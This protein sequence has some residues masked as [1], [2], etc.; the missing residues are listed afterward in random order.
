MGAQRV[1]VVG[2]G[3]AG[4]ATCWSLAREH[5]VEAV[6][7][8]RERQP[9]AHSTARNAAILRTAIRDPLLHALARESARFYREPPP[10]F[11]A[12]RLLRPCGVY[13]GAPE[14]AAAELAAWAG[15]PACAG[16]AREVPAARLREAWPLL[17]PGIA[18]CWLSQEDGVI[19]THALL[20]GFLRQAREAGAELRTGVGAVDLLRDRDGAVRGV[21]AIGPA[22]PVPE[23]IEADA[24]VL[25]GGGWAAEPAAAA[26]LTL[27]LQPR[28]R[29]LLVTAPLAEVKPEAPVA[30]FFGEELYFRPESGGLLISVCDEQEVEPPAGERADA[31][32]L[33]VFAHK[34]RRWLPGCVDAPVTQLLAG[35]RTFAADRRFVLGPD[36]RA[37][38]LHWAAALGGHGIS[39]AYAA[40]RIAAASAA[41]APPPSVHAE[42][43]SPARLL[44]GAAA[45]TERAD[46]S[47]P[48]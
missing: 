18:R 15:D 19:D 5:G 1:V 7:I 26:G 45:R 41:G 12:H 16:D 36:P 44:S 23:A 38:G 47:L 17:A 43:F 31:A 29:H 8:E 25:A 2:G 9:G 20:H 34:L 4:A 22:L 46:A 37:A 3:I 24:V 11:A 6:L 42:A 32:V 39:C 30:W 13:L 10:G 40:G 33:E 35:M 21:R 28:R 14:E 27:E 48:A